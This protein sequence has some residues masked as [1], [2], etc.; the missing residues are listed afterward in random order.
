M[1]ISP[2]M[3]V[4]IRLCLTVKRN[5]SDSLPTKAYRGAGDG[6]RL[7]GNHLAGNA[8]GGIGRDQQNIGDANLL[9]RR[10]LQRGEQGVRRGVRTGQE[11]PQ[12]AKERREEGKRVAGMGQRQARVDDSPE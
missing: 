7:R 6:D 10:C 8:A 12:P 9:R 3:Q 2:T 11:Y 5:R 1:V 4:K